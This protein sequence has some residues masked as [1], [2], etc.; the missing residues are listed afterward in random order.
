MTC[1][2]P[3]LTSAFFYIC[4]AFYTF[5]NTSAHSILFSFH[6]YPCEIGR[7]G[8]VPVLEIRFLRPRTTEVFSQVIHKDNDTSGTSTQ[9]SWL[10]ALSSFV[11]TC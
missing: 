10:H 6:Q 5:H 4:L 8:D 2:T 7:C 3:S 9:D 11:V 1:A